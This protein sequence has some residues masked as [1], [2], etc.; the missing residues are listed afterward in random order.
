MDPDSTDVFYARRK[1]DGTWSNPHNVSDRDSPSQYPS[2]AVDPNGVVHLAWS[3]QLYTGGFKEI[4]YSRLELDGTWSAI[5]NVSLTSTT[6]NH[7]KLVIEPN[8][9]VHA[10]W[11]E[12]VEG[13]YDIFYA[14]P[15]PADQGGDSVLSQVLSIPQTMNNPT[16]SFLYQLG[17]AHPQSGT[18]LDVQVDDGLTTTS[19]FSTAW[20]TQGW[21]HQWA[22]LTPWSDQIITLTWKVHQEAGAAC[23]WAFLDE[24]SVGSTYPDLWLNNDSPIDVAMP[25]Q[26]VTFNLHYGNQGGAVAESVRITDS[27]PSG[28][29]FV[30]ASPA[31]SSSTPTLVWEVGNLPAKS[32]TY[33]IIITASVALEAPRGSYLINSTQI[34]TETEL[35]LANNTALASIWVGHRVYLPLIAKKHWTFEP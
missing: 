21:S 8:G 5:Q 17:G 22:N 31:P 9:L 24:A 2:M 19:V 14:R 20:G 18:W 4:A 23:T 27:L 30:A 29:V 13:T 1:S 28:L 26:E 15:T 12:W 33:A 16:L 25:G 7:P 32:E 35:E 3:D 11:L 34:G 6:S 10:V